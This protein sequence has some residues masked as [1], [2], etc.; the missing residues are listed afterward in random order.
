MSVGRPV[1]LA[2]GTA[3]LISLETL[4]WVTNEYSVRFRYD[5]ADN[6]KLAELRKRHSLD[7]VEGGGG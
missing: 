4:P 3:T 1:A 7:A 2:G 5:S 6:P